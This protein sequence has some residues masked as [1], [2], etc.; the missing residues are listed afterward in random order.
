MPGSRCKIS[1]RQPHLAARVYPLYFPLWHALRHPALHD[2]KLRNPSAY[3]K[4]LGC[5][6]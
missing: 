5:G 1:P 2:G 6:R 4:H 3:G